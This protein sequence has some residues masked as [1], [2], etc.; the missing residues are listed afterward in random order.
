MPKITRLDKF[1]IVLPDDNQFPEEQKL[2]SKQEWNNKTTQ[3]TAKLYYSI[4]EK[5][6]NNQ[7]LN[8]FKI[9]ASLKKQ[10]EVYISKTVAKE[11]RR[12]S[13]G[14]GSGLFNLP[15]RADLV[16]QSLPPFATSQCV[17]QLKNQTC[18]QQQ[19]QV[20]LDNL[21][22][23]NY[24]LN[25][26]VKTDDRP[27]TTVE[28]T[29]T[30]KDNDSKIEEHQMDCQKTLVSYLQYCPDTAITPKIAVNTKIDGVDT[31]LIGINEN[32][33]PLLLNSIQL[34]STQGGIKPDFQNKAI[35]NNSIE[36]IAPFHKQTEVLLSEQEV[37]PDFY[38]EYFDDINIGYP[39][40]YEQQKN[41]KLGTETQIIVGNNT[42]PASIKSYYQCNDIV[43]PFYTSDHTVFRLKNISDGLITMTINPISFLPVKAE[44]DYDNILFYAHNVEEVTRLKNE[45]QSG[46]AKNYTVNITAW[47]QIETLEKQGKQWSMIFLFTG[48]LSV[49]FILFI[50]GALA[51]INIDLKKREIAQ[52]L[53]LGYSK[54]F[55]GL[56]VIFEYVLLTT[57]GATLALGVGELF[58]MA[59]KWHLENTVDKTDTD[60]SVFA[61]S[62]TIDILA[63]LNLF[64]FVMPVTIFIAV[65][66]AYITAKT[67]PVDLLD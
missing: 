59:I 65:V 58:F 61:N 49:I 19:Q 27:L 67:D 42:I 29:L 10:G 20:I 32:S 26:I 31:Q 9:V 66:A 38:D 39:E 24:G 51:K 25:P 43:C 4:D 5:G 1:D 6:S 17:I 57:I 41:I 35:V 16:Q 14:L 21:K 18:N 12:Y 64:G 28:I 54:F 15:A 56:L 23:A 45:L 30:K 55:V 7:P 13:N 53:L 44:V 3:L 60:F 22:L 63:F 52:L 8:N 50:L 11:L 34:N 46:I 37:V 48:I 40:E 62:F 36:L 2:Y 47:Y 33:Y